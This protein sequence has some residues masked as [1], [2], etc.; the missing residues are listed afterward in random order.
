[1]EHSKW[2]GL[3]FCEGRKE[4]GWGEVIKKSREE[5]G[6]GR[7]GRRGHCTH[8]QYARF[9]LDAILISKKL[10]VVHYA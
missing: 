9:I 3:D 8:K 5:G 7:G 4:R 10:A 6:G 1:M 2:S